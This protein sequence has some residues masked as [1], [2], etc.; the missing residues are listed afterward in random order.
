MTEL[1]PQTLGGYQHLGRSGQG[2]R[3]KPTEGRMF[4]LKDVAPAVTDFMW[5]NTRSNRWAGRRGGC[6]QLMACLQMALLTTPASWACQ[7]ALS[8]CPDSASSYQSLFLFFDYYLTFFYYG[9]FT[10]FC[11]FLLRSK[12]T[13]SYVCIYILFLTLSSK[14]LDVVPY[15]TQ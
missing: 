12:V 8:L 14:Q 15:A 11:Q 4:S 5:P 6:P 3:G 9:R 1:R 7:T 2:H 10:M 13:Q